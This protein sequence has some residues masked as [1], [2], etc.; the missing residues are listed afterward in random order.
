MSANHRTTQREHKPQRKA[1]PMNNETNIQLADSTEYNPNFDLTMR[2][3]T[4]I[5]I[6]VMLLW[7]DGKNV[8]VN[9]EYGGVAWDSNSYKV[10]GWFRGSYSDAIVAA[11]KLA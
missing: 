8:T 5:K 11:K 9:R 6:W 2:D 3:Y 4:Q 10:L 7:S 1:N